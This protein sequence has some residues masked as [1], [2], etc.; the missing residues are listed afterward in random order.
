MEDLDNDHSGNI[1]CDDVSPIA[2]HI[3]EQDSATKQK[4]SELFGCFDPGNNKQ[5]S[6]YDLPDDIHIFPRCD[7]QEELLVKCISN[8]K[9]CK[10]VRSLNEK[11]RQFFYHVL[12]SVKTSNDPLR[13]F[14]SGGAG[15][16]KSTVTNV[17]YEALIRYLNSMAG[18][19]LDK[20]MSLKQLQ[21][22]KQHSTSKEIHYIQPL[23][24]LP[25]RDLNIMHLIV[26]D[27]T[28]LGQS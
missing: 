23:K 28:Q 16:G 15:V 2:Q 11:Q 27:L 3:N 4:P 1:I 5:H 19:N 18:E 8:D 25:I 21:Q 26:T 7:D 14:L 9:Y 20:S 22:E 17:Q 12:H 13:L 6:Q 10:L 24:Y